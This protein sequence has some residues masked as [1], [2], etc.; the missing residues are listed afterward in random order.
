L[1]LFVL[2]SHRMWL[3]NFLVGHWDSMWWCVTHSW[4]R[5][6][7]NKSLILSHCVIFSWVFKSSS[8]QNLFI[9]LYCPSEVIWTP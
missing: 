6:R 4:R 3:F 1:F 5:C 7:D 9:S 2:H 8:I